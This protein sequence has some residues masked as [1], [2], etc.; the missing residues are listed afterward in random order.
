MDRSTA[1]TSASHV[2]GEAN[3]PYCLTSFIW[4]EDH[5]RWYLLC[6]DLHRTV[7]LVQ[8]KE[9]KAEETTVRC[10]AVRPSDL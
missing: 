5:R 9:H 3:A 6:M 10:G 2:T 8:N 1:H 4:N 7:F